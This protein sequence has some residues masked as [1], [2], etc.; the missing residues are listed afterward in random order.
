MTQLQ[1]STG[2]SLDDVWHLEIFFFAS[3]HLWIF[4]LANFILQN[5]TK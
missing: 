4:F 5:L 2:Q 1:N 3:F